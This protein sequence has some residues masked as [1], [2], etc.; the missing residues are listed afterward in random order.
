MDVTMKPKPIIW[1]PVFGLCF[2]NFVYCSITFVH[3]PSFYS[4]VLR[5]NDVLNPVPLL[6]A[7]LLEKIGLFDTYWLSVPLLVITILLW[8]YC[9]AWGISALLHILQR[10]R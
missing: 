3:P 6:V 8:A 10:V 4:A 1:V 5:F 7:D 2:M 9:V